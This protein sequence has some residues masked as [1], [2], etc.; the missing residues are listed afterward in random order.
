MFTSRPLKKN[1]NE[2]KKRITHLEMQIKTSK[3]WWA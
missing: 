3:K 1:L 2:F